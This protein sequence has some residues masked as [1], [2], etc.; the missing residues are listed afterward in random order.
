MCRGLFSVSEVVEGVWRL[1]EGVVVVL[2]VLVV[3]CNF[4]TLDVIPYR[5]V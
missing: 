3:G 4:R 1:V 5:M 2:V